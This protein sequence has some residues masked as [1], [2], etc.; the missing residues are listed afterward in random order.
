MNQ[1]LELKKLLLK[2]ELGLLEHGI[3]ILI[4]TETGGAVL[5]M[6]LLKLGLK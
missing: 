1:A 5:Q 6:R 3:D 4:I 2:T